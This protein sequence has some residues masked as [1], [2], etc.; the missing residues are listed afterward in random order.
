MTTVAAEPPRCV[1]AT[2]AISSKIDRAGP[3]EAEPAAWPVLWARCWKRIRTWQLPPLW[4]ARDWYEEARAQGGLADCLARRQ[5]DPGR[6][7]PLDAFVYRR[8]VSAVWT[9][10]R[11]EWSYGRRAVPVEVAQEDALASARPD[12]ALGEQMSHA[13]EHLSQAERRLLRHLFW[14][15]SSLEELCQEAGLRREALQKRKARALLKLRQM[16]QDSA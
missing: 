5:F 12:P 1:C 11:Q 3:A 4:A 6:G 9:R 13:L 16:L 7:V 8:V 10:Y 14:D 15:G 2:P